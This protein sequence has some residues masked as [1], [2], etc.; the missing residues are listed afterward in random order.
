M[1]LHGVHGRWNESSY[2]REEEERNQIFKRNSVTHV[3]S[4]QNDSQLDVDFLVQMCAVTCMTIVSL[5]WPHSLSAVV[6]TVLGYFARVVRFAAARGYT[7]TISG[8]YSGDGPR[9]RTAGSGS[10][11]ANLGS[12]GGGLVTPCETTNGR[13]PGLGGRVRI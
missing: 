5:P 7:A 9:T 2:A 4:L 3:T 11:A 13:L 8:S 1:A 6:Q 12:S 10:P